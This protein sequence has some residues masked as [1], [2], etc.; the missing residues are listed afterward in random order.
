ML[1]DGSVDDEL[2]LG[3]LAFFLRRLGFG[4]ELL[5]DVADDGVVPLLGLG[6]F[7]G[8]GA[9][10]GGGTGV[11]ADLLQTRG[12]DGLFHGG[13]VLVMRFCFL[14]FFLLVEME[15]EAEVEVEV[16]MRVGRDWS[17]GGR[18][19]E[20]DAVG[21]HCRV[22]SRGVVNGNG[23]AA[24]NGRDES[25]VGRVVGLV[26]SGLVCGVWC[27]KMDVDGCSRCD[28]F[29]AGV[30]WRAGDSREREREIVLERERL[31][32]ERGQS[33]NPCWVPAP[34]CLPCK[35]PGSCRVAL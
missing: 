9:A 31:E 29:E 1:D 7:V 27:K 16:Q 13:F 22:T 24:E 19:A 26:W 33:F 35:C 25:R 14:V 3:R 30:T 15:V 34:A 17:C 32:R 6:V 20:T 12:G 11:G 5:E 23:R 10:D 21:G 4:D 8:G 18:A 2:V 28:G